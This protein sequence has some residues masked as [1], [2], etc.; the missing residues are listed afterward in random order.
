MLQ[1]KNYIS[2]FEKIVRLLIA[3]GTTAE[4]CGATHCLEK[5]IALRYSKDIL[6]NVM[7]E[8]SICWYVNCSFTFVDRQ[9]LQIKSLII[10]CRLIGSLGTSINNMRNGFINP[11]SNPNNISHFSFKICYIL[12]HEIAIDGNLS[13]SINNIRISLNL[14]NL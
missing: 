1:M 9:K 11:G 12:R 7:K 6:Y 14:T 4:R 8:M 5:N 10:L 3:D 13:L 2:I